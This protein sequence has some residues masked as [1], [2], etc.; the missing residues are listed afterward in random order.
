MQDTFARA[1][2]RPSARA[3]IEYLVY[4]REARF[5]QRLPKVPIM[6]YTRYP[7]VARALS[8]ARARASKGI[9]HTTNDDLGVVHI[10]SNQLFGIFTPPPSVINR[11]QDP[12]PLLTAILRNQG[13]TPPPP[14]FFK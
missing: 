9:L 11:N 5:H 8:L 6:L 2:T 3:T 14:Q 7:I 10:L 1:R 4:K 12:T 13:L